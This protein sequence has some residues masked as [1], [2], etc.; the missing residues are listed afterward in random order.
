MNI[1]AKVALDKE[2]HPERFCKQNRC[3][4]R[5]LVCHPMTREMVP[6]KGCQSGWCPRHTRAEQPVVPA[7][8]TERRERTQVERKVDSMLD[9]VSFLLWGCP[10]DVLD[11]VRADA[12]IAEASMRFDVNLVEQGDLARKAAREN[13]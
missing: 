11:P 2:K 3:L 8:A 5:V 9:E 7:P 12:V 10:F 4:W 1:Q 13:V 6:A